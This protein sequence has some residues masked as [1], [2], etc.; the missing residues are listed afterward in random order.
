MR[1]LGLRFLNLNSLRGEHEIRFDRPPFSESGLF[2]ITG[3]TGAGKTTILDA[4]TVALYGKVHRH[5]KEV[6]EMMSRHTAECY[7][8]VEFEVNSVHYRSKWSLKRGRGKIE[9]AIQSEKMEFC[10]VATGKFLG[11][12]TATSIKQAVIECCGLDYSQF[13]RSVM[14][15]QGDFTRFLK[16]KDDERSELLEK[17]TDTG[18]YSDISRFVY[19]KQKEEKEKLNTLQLQLE[20]VEIL[21][22]EE[23]EAFVRS[24]TELLHE[25]ETAKTQQTVFVAKLNWVN[26]LAKLR[27]RQATET[28]ALA[29]DQRR[30]K[31]NVLH[32]EQLAQHQ[33]AVVFQPSLLDVERLQNQVEKTVQLLEEWNDKLPEE[34]K[35]MEEAFQ[36]AEVAKMTVEKAQVAIVEAEPLLGKIQQM[37]AA[38]HHA[39]EQV[40]KHRIQLQHI[41]QELDLARIAKEEKAGQLQ[42]LQK[43]IDQ[44]DTWV[45]DHEGEKELEKLIVVVTQSYKQQEEIRHA[46]ELAEQELSLL[47]MQK[48]EGKREWETSEKRKADLQQEWENGKESV[49]LLFEKWEATKEGRTLEDLESEQGM[50]P[51]LISDCE[52]Q[53]KLAMA[54]RKK[55]EDHGLGSEEQ[56][57]KALAYEQSIKAFQLVEK[58]KEQADLAL[59]DYRKLLELEQRI[60]K[61]EGDR[62]L[63]RPEEPC[64]LCGSVHH[65][66]AE[67][68]KEINLSGTAR[69]KEEQEAYVNRLIKQV[70][71]KNAEVATLKLA[72]ETGAK[73]L[74]QGTMELEAVLHEFGEIN[75]RLPKPLDIERPEIVLAIIHKKKQQLAL[76]QK[77]IAE[78]RNTKEKWTKTQQEVAAKEV[79][80]MEAQGKSETLSL[81]IKGW[82]EAHAKTSSTYKE[83]KEKWAR[84]VEEISETLSPY[85]LVFE[86]SN[87]AA[88][89]SKIESRWQ[90]YAQTVR[91]LGQF[92]LEE[93]QSKAELEGL[94]K[95]WEEKS[96]RHHQLTF[97]LQGLQ[98]ELNAQKANRIHLFGDKLPSRE[99]E[100][101]QEEAKAGQQ[102]KDKKLEVLREKQEHVRTTQAHL[103]QGRQTL[104]ALRQELEQGTQALHQKLHTVGIPSVEALKKLFLTE[105]EVKRVSALERALQMELNAREKALEAISKELEIEI[106]KNTASETGQELNSQLD[107]L[108]K[109]ISALDQELGRLQ[110]VLQEDDRLKVRFEQIAAQLEVQKKGYQKWAKLSDLIG[111]ADGKKFRRFAQGLTLAR[112]TDL[113]NLHLQKLSDRYRILKSKESDL[114]LRI[115]DGYQADVV[116][117]MTTLSG[118][119]SFLVSLALALGL[120]DLAS[121]KVQINSLFIDEGFGTLDADTLDTAISALENL[122]AKG[123]TIGII[124]HVEA[125][126]ERIA[127]QIQISKQPGGH[128]KIKVKSYGREGME[129]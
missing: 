109:N 89:V 1:I 31:E 123:K 33:K 75:A 26:G 95:A 68:H 93:T 48:A 103:A 92:K 57:Q 122:Q 121:R 63:L 99:R 28:V 118:G 73:Q 115:V 102:E 29:E 126:K 76:I 27:E 52:Q 119:E 25:K 56:Q 37:D 107:L 88:L 69:K 127:T 45:H 81:K 19:D 4:I 20:G 46:L 83:T 44:L 114:E 105:E 47:Q 43:K 51:S 72:L 55:K 61:Y 90:K 117:P 50:L 91:D 87:P 113:A 5:D 22:L 2:A 64:P 34:Q 49:R 67:S 54:Y 78:W 18:I 100:R 3:P 84:I 96:G 120:S 39:N 85:H 70:S 12:H 13:L 59:L 97:D 58:E 53:Y 79:D 14:L 110:S 15:S 71:E 42:I 101:L 106:R 80:V 65:P 30:W 24:Q 74:A 125:L 129:V 98:T 82:E 86:A 128:S 21:S 40:E 104:Q 9:G 60:Q 38:L 35:A 17:I 77:E 8:E 23:R 11:G 111:S 10:E 94:V 108:E 16:A 7:A 62:Q 6:E 41:A 32:F 116:R 112:L 124:S 66:Y 36:E